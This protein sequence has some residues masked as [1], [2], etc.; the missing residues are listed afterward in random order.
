MLP[1]A[2]QVQLIGRAGHVPKLSDSTKDYCRA[3]L[4][5]YQDIGKGEH[6]GRTQVHQL[7]AWNEVA[8]QLGCRVRRGDRLLVQGKL[9]YHRCVMRE[10]THVRA[11][12]HISHFVLLD[13]SK[14]GRTMG[15]SEDALHSFDGE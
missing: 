14:A 12:I 13:S 10:V 2:N 11:E 15:K 1:I 3:T 7:V 4:R 5:L 6:T 9:L 8:R